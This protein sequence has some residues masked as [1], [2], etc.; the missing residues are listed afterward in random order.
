M[1]LKRKSTIKRLVNEEGEIIDI[2]KDILNQIKTFYTKLYSREDFEENF[3]F[4]RDFFED[5][6]TLKLKRES[7][8]NWEGEIFEGEC[9]AALK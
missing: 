1:Q 9:F 5:L 3:A 2:E 4:D 6:P 8:A 7:I